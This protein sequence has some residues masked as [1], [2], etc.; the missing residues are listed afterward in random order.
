MEVLGVLISKKPE[1]LKVLE[2]NKTE[3]IVPLLKELIDT[4]KQESDETL[5]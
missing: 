2:V 1:L 3:T 5:M 4:K